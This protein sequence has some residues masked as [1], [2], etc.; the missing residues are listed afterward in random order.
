MSYNASTVKKWFRSKVKGR[1]HSEH[2]FGVYLRTPV[3]HDV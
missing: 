3:K 1:A 2:T